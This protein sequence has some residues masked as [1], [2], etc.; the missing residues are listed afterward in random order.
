MVIG[1]D[2]GARTAHRVA[3]GSGEPPIDL[4]P[5]PDASAAVLDRDARPPRR[6]ADGDGLTP[7]IALTTGPP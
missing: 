3:F 7:R 6:V 1:K 2:A 5:P 4:P